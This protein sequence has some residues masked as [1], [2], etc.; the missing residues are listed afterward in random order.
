M[1]AVFAVSP[2]GQII[3]QWDAIKAYFGTLWQGIKQYASGAW[4]VITGI[5]SGDPSQIIGGL[6]KMWTAINTVFSGWPARFVQWGADM[7]Q[8]LVNGILG[9][10]AA[11]GKAITGVVGG[12]VD[13]FK[14]LLGINSP[15]RV[16]ARFGDYTMQGYANGLDR[17]G[18]APVASVSRLG[19]RIRKA[20][21]GIVLA[22][23]LPMAA[24]APAPPPA[25]PAARIVAPAAAAPIVEPRIALQA[26]APVTAPG[27][28]RPQPSPSPSATAGNHYEIHIHPAPG[29]DAQAI[30]RAVATELDRRERQRGAVGRSR[31]SDID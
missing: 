21:A 14:A 10:A 11:V 20:G 28:A 29:M 30:A 1:K 5:F 23:T 22:S 4:G 6:L 2:L 27:L 7:L 12:A 17:T 26:P 16:F 13:K 8:G 9:M 19:A 18:D 3:A 24:A 15:S 31:L 25:A